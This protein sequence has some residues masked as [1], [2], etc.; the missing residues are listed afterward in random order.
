MM[1][2]YHANDHECWRIKEI[3]AA[4]RRIPAASQLLNELILRMT[5]KTMP[6]RPFVKKPRK[7]KYVKNQDCKMRESVDVDLPSMREQSP[8]RVIGMMAK[9][10]LHQKQQFSATTGKGFLQTLRTT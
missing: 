8:T 1:G 5:R 2:I 6:T 3:K 10:Q 7:W 9:L 4:T